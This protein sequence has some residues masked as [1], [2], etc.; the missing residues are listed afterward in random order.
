MR[1]AR[2]SR[3]PPTPAPMP[4]LAL[5]ERPDESLSSMPT[6]GLGLIVA[7]G[8]GSVLLRGSP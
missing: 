6:R 1:K 4:I 5:V 3:P 2:A 8:D 7:V